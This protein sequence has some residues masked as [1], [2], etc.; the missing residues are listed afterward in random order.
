MAALKPR[1]GERGGVPR[2]LQ[3]GQPRQRLLERR[4]KPG[5]EVGGSGRG[6]AGN[7]GLSRP[8]ITQIGSGKVSHRLH[9]FTQIF[10]LLFS[11]FPTQYFFLVN[12][13]E[14]N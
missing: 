13:L 14:N 4:E 7:Y 10:D 1:R 6:A 8:Q 3:R 11:C 9:R 5:T 2:A 12:L